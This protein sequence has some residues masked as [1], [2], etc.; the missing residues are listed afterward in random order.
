MVRLLALISVGAEL[1]FKETPC[2]NIE[3][4]RVQKREVK[5]DAGA[6]DTHFLS[7]ILEKI[8][9]KMLNCVI[10]SLDARRAFFS[11]KIEYFF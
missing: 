7:E 8:T 5:E 9:F 2:N 11:S 6:R 4:T 10:W 1:P 3:K